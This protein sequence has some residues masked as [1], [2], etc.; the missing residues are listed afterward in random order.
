MIPQPIVAT[1]HD[2]LAVKRYR[3]WY[4]SERQ[5][6]HGTQETVPDDMTARI[7]RVERTGAF[8]S[9]LER[10]ILTKD[11]ERHFAR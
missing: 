1:A 10:T 7:E 5:K 11:W 4:L 3:A 8:F 9:E 6:N 2:R